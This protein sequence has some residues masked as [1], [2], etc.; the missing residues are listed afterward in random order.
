M[1]GMRAVLVDSNVLIDIQRRDREWYEW[2]RASLEREGE[3]SIL[4]INPIIYADVSHGYDR[5]NELDEALP[6]ETY[7][8]EPLPWPAAFIASKVHGEY[9]RRGGARR[10]IL[11]DFYIGAHALVAGMVVLT[12]D[13]RRY[14]SYFPAL[15]VVAP[16]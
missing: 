8:R 16:D 12:R 15:E 2:S 6:E 4:V 7:R 10:A 14:R 1:S 11:P 9:R 5:R 13:A 3:R